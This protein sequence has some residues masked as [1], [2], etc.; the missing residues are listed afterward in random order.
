MTKPM[1][2]WKYQKCGSWWIHGTDE[3][4]IPPTRCYGDCGGTDFERHKVFSTTTS[5]E[6]RD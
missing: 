4:Q 5:S 3:R 1:L 6:A 2:T